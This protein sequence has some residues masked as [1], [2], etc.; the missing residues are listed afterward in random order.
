MTQIVGQQVVIENRP[1]AG[2]SLAAELAARAPKDGYTLYLGAS[3]NVA[4]AA[5]NPKLPFDIDKDFAPIALVA[6]AAVVLVVHPSIGVGSVPELVAL[7]RSKPGEIN[8]ASVGIG[9]APHL[10]AELLIQ[11][12]GIKL[13]HV[14]YQGS[15]QAVTDLLAGRTQVMFS[16]ASTVV[17][18]IQ[19]GQLKA[20]AS[21]TEKRV[22]ILPDVPTM[23]EIGMSDFETSIWFGLMAPAGTPASIVA[24]LNDVVAA[25]CRSP[26]V[27]AALRAQGIEPTS[28][29]PQEFAAFVRDQ[30]ELHRQLVKDVDLKISE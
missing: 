5:M 18:L 2:G 8:Y 20:L 7:A 9:S 26:D 25:A 29:R 21:A 15:P 12:A 14:P 28:S 6:Y 4:N 16:P 23:A 22:G 13:Q 11:R 27:V 3:A 10:S 17:P 1:G 19:S 30:L 24:K